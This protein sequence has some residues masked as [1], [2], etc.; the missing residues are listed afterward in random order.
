MDEII[1]RADSYINDPTLAQDTVDIMRDLVT[2]CKRLHA[3]LI[4]LRSAGGW[5]KDVI[6]LELSD[7]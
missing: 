5:V 1:A 6:D 2:E 4:S 3:V 7:V